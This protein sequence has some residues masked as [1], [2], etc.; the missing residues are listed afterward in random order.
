M[1]QNYDEAMYNQ[2]KAWEQEQEFQ[3]S[4]SAKA[5]ADIRA[6]EESEIQPNEP[7]QEQ[8]KEF[9]EW[10]GFTH[11]IGS[12]MW[13]YGKYKETNAWWVAP[14]GKKYVDLPLIDPNSL[15][16]YAVPKLVEKLGKHRTY[17]IL[18]NCLSASILL[19]KPLESEIFREIMEVIHDK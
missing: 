1:T 18:S 7:T 10:C 13:N 12:K 14:N 4:E 16:K 6:E 5:E 3:A 2:H 8:I 15:F 17:L 9:W 11:N 19:G